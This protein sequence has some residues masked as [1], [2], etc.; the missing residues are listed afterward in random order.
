MIRSK[1]NYSLLNMKN[2]IKWDEPQSKLRTQKTVQS[3]KELNLNFASAEA[4]CEGGFD[5]VLLL[6]VITVLFSC[7]DN[8]NT[9]SI[10]FPGAE[11]FGA[12]ASGGRGGSVYEVTNLNDNGPGSLRSGIE[13][14][15]PRTIVFRVS[16]NIRLNSPISIR[17]GN[18]TIAGQ[19]APGDGICISNYNTSVNADNIIIRHLRFRLGDEAGNTADA[20]SCGGDNV[21]NKNVIIDH[22]SVSWGIDEN[23]S[24]Y[25]NDSTTVQWCIISESLDSS[26]HEKGAHGFGGIWG[27][28]NA[29]FHHNLFA[30]N[31]SRNPRFASSRFPG[32]VELDLV[33]F[34]NNIIYNWGQNSI[35]GGEKRKHNIVANYF[36]PGPATPEGRLSFRIFNPMKPAGKFFIESNYVF[37]SDSA[38]SDNWTHGVQGVTDAEK[39]AIRSPSPFYAASIN[40]TSAEQAYID[41]LLKVGAIA[42]K[43]DTVDKRIID[44]VVNG[45][46]KYGKRFAGGGKGLIDSQKDVGGWPELKTYNVP[47]DSD[48]DGMPDQWEK[49]HRLDAGNPNDRNNRSDNG[50]TN[51]ERYLNEIAAK[52]N[53][54]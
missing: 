12:W 40:M 30:H 26:L 25:H 2:L 44:E 45:T 5:K 13:M 11:G 32:N 38:T 16:G 51:L 6:I 43:R 1:T 49:S 46:A 10:A 28:M 8:P 15:D 39:I 41:V 24:F 42:P 21:T 31:K 23:L 14:S 50:Y 36:K 52:V 29:S 9:P 3:V 19:T 18:L 27:G 4:L 33:D 53:V 54:I 34:R 47:A 22:C 37:G 20:F 17:N 48:H 35:Y 7:N